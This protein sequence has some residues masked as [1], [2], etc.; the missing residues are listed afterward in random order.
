MS[1]CKSIPSF[2]P[3][4]E[5]ELLSQ[6]AEARVWKIPAFLPPDRAAIAKERFAK[7]YRHPVL[8]ERI[9][10]ARCKAEAKALLRARRGGVICPAV[11]G[12]QIPV[13]YLEHLG[14]RTVREYL[15]EQSANS[16]TMMNPEQT[17]IA[18]EIGTAIGKLHN[19]GTVHGD[20]TT[21]NMMY[22]AAN[23]VA[24]IDFGLAKVSPNPEEMAVDLYVLERALIST[25]PELEVTS[26]LPDILKA[27]KATSNKSDAV[28]QRLSAVRLRGRKRECFG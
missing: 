20:L 3:K 11:W 17:N 27:Y 25:H 23:M 5:W 15:V 1:S 26:F 24:L 21:S 10:K 28:L 9:T 14:G 16:M 7:T 12:V 8:D 13:L 18:V 22:T 19:T 2:E 6:G 4:P